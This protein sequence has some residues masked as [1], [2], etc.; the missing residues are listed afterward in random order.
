MSTITFGAAPTAAA[1]APVS[2]QAPKR[3]G[4][5]ARALAR[6]IAARQKQAMDEI[7]RHGVVLPRELEQAE[8]KV[9]ERGADSLPFQR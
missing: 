3:K 8:W 5:F 7:R 1:A 6:V 9:S 4:W 2:A